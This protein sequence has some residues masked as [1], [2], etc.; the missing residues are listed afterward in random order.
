MC[1]AMTS[2][3]RR[4]SRRVS[5]ATIQL[6]NSAFNKGTFDYFFVQWSFATKIIIICVFRPF[7]FGMAAVE[8]V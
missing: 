2:L 5:R 4:L 6:L 3:T 1:A 8:G 7:R